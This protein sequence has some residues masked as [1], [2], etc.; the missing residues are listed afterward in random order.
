MRFRHVHSSAFEGAFQTMALLTLRVVGIDSVQHTSSRLIDDLSIISFFGRATG[1]SPSIAF[2]DYDGSPAA[3][4][5][6]VKPHNMPLN[7]R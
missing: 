2:N 5:S 6:P 3:W 7:R 1:G 4:S